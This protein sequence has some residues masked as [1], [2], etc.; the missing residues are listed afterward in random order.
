[1]FG[2]RNG[3]ENAGIGLLEDKR[4]RK[5]TRMVVEEPG[6]G[7]IEQGYRVVIEKNLYPHAK[8]GPIDEP[9]GNACEDPVNAPRAVH[10]E[11]NIPGALKV[12]ETLPVAVSSGSIPGTGKEGM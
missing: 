7:H 4:I 2:E 3:K 8:G 10:I 5:R 12:L 11:K 9:I 1:M 6:H